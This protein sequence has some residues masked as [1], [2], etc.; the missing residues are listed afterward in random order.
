MVRA[1]KAAVTNRINE[2]RGAPGQPVWQSNYYKRIIRDQRELD[3]V[4]QYILDNPANWAED[5][6]YV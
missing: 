4:R 1:F 2:E 6:E 3:A 5:E